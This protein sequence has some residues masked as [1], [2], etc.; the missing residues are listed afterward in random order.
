MGPE[1]IIHPSGK[2]CKKSNKGGYF[3]DELSDLPAVP[4]QIPGSRSVQTVH[5]LPTVRPSTSRQRTSTAAIPPADQVSDVLSGYIIDH[6]SRTVATQRSTI[7]P[8]TDS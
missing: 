6:K 7:Q 4:T 3:D 1:R 2:L 5:S 8:Q